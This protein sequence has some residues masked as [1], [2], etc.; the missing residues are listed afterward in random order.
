V[1]SPLTAGINGSRI[2]VTGAG[3]GIGREI[4][5]HLAASGAQVF[6]VDVDADALEKTRAGS[7]I[8]VATCDVSDEKQVQT[9]VHAASDAM[10]G[11]DAVVN[12]AAIVAVTRKA[13]AQV[14]VE[15]FDRVMAVNVRGPWLVYRAAAPLLASGGGGSI[16]NLTSET[17]YTGSRDLAHYVASKAAVIG[18]TRALAREAGPDHIRVNA[19]GPGFTDTEGAR[20]IG[21]PD[22]YDTSATPLGRVGR[23]ADIVGAVGF[24]LSPASAFISG[25]VLLVNGG[26]VMS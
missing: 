10:G 15:E 18:L 9:V 7:E 2:L 24:L 3:R 8:A 26:R 16:V 4:A 12:N 17:A 25:Q 20:A 23:P 11:L 19:V 1:T 21:D 14:G 6:A 22:L 13:S 5:Q